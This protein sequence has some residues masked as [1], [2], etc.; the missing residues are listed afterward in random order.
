MVDSFLNI[1]HLNTEKKETPKQVFSSENCEIFKST[2]F[3]EHQQTTASEPTFNV[4]IKLSH[5]VFL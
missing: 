3:E 4:H 2:Y 1:P 5:D